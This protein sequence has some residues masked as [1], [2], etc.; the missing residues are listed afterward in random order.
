M[1]KSVHEDIILMKGLKLTPAA[2]GQ[3][4]VVCYLKECKAKNTASVV[5]G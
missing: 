3:T 2:T 1:T 4:D 5:F